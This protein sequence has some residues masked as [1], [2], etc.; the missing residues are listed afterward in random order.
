MKLAEALLH[1][2]RSYGA[3]AFNMLNA[4]AGAVAEKSPVV[5]V[6]GGAQARLGDPAVV[7]AKCL[8]APKDT[9]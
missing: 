3:G 9:A 8:H 7:G 6:S 5:V 1:G 4:V 2:L